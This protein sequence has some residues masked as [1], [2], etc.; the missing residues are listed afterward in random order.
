M[1]GLVGDTGEVWAVCL[2][3]GCRGGDERTSVGCILEV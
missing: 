3:G 2:G 1:V